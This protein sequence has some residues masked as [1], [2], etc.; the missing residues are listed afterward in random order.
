MAL[1]YSRRVSAV[2]GHFEAVLESVISTGDLIED[3]LPS[4][5]LVV[6]GTLTQ[7]QRPAEMGRSG[8]T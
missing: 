6:G 3:M 2:R 5:Y 7:F 8:G 1:L 4:I